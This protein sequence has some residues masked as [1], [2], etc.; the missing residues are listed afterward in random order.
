MENSRLVICCQQHGWVNTLSGWVLATREAA[1]DA[2]YQ[3]RVEKH[4]IDWDGEIIVAEE[5]AIG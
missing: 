3:H 2:A 1:V 4:S 5:V